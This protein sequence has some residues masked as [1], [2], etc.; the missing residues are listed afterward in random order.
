MW[1]PELYQRFGD[2]RSRPFFDLVGRVAAEAPAV[3]V[4]LG[5]GPGT[6]TAALARRWPGAAGPRDRQLGRDDRG[7]AGAAGRAASGSASRSVT[8][9]TGARRPAWT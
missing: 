3:V 4:D 1:D 7:R 9:G 2:E 8:S 5:C 6:L